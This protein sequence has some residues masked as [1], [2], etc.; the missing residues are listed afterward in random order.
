[1]VFIWYSWNFTGKS[2]IFFAQSCAKAD[3]DHI[4]PKDRSK[5]RS[6]QSDKR[7]QENNY[8]QSSYRF[9]YPYH[10][11]YCYI[12][13]LYIYISLS[14]YP[15]IYLSKYI[16]SYYL[17]LSIYI[18]IYMCVYNYIYWT[19]MSTRGFFVPVPGSLGG[20]SLK[21]PRSS[22]SSA[23]GPDHLDLRGA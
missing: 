19:H 22:K 1:M 11:K 4:H 12:C 10:P 15:S 20:A 14:L 9:L 17:Y 2:Y 5:L 6:Q 7:M 16:L 18:Y 8:P 21:G 3:Q 23:S 13:I